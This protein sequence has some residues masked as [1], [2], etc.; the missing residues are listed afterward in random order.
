MSEYKWDG[1]TVHEHHRDVIVS[2][3]LE[4]TE[5]TEFQRTII[6]RA[7][8]EDLYERAKR[9]DGGR[10]FVT[11][12]EGDS[13]HEGVEASGRAILRSD[14]ESVCE[15]NMYTVL[16]FATTREWENDPTRSVFYYKGAE[17]PESDD[18]ISL[19]DV[20]VVRAWTAYPYEKF[21]AH[22]DAVHKV[23]WRR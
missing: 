11:F 20:G 12:L 18:E 10:I 17:V 2:E 7:V 16:A 23:F 1:K 13:K 14:D 19:D 4:D 21:A 5:A 22:P 3:W 9:V 8:E 15:G 6:R